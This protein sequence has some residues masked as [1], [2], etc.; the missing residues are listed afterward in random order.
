MKRTSRESVYNQA[1]D[2]RRFI[3]A[4]FTGTVDNVHFCSGSQSN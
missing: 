2:R 3:G 1:V 4:A